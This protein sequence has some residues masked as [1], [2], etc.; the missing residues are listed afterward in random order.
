MTRVSVIV[1]TY[2][3]PDSLERCIR[4]L[5]HQ[6]RVPDQVV[7]TVRADDAISHQH[8]EE[9]CRALPALPIERVTVNAA[10]KSNAINAALKVA[11]GDVLCFTDDDAE[12]FPDWVERIER[13][14]ADGRIGGVGGRD[15]V[16]HPHGR[17]DGVCH[18]VGRLSWYGRLTGNH[19]LRLVPPLVRRVDILKGV[20]MAFTRDALGGFNLDKNLRWKGAFHDEI[21]YCLYVTNRGKTLLYDPDL[22]VTHRPAP[23]TWSADR[24]DFAAMQ[25]ESAFN[26]TY[27]LLKHLPWPRKIAFLAYQLLVGQRTA[28]GLLTFPYTLTRRDMIYGQFPAGPRLQAMAIAGKL[29]ALYI[30]TRTR[31]QAES[32]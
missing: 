14:L 17:D 19:H 26:L 2:G 24:R 9:L 11:T 4:A 6:T 27:L 7:V 32:R 8:L 29:A 10:G 28:L 21:D 12:P 1:P 25:F 31:I 30:F 23:R 22:Q 5:S 3:R 18:V 20:N 13:T 16:I 15:I